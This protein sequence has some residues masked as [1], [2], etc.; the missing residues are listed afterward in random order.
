MAEPMIYRQNLKALAKQ[1]I[2]DYI[3]AMDLESNNKLPREEQL[4]EIIGVSR[5]TLRSA[6]NELASDG[7]VFRRQGKGTF[8]N[9]TRMEIKLSFN[10]AGH[11][12]DMIRDS[13]Y[14]PRIALLA[15]E[16]I[17]A[18]ADM[19]GALAIAEGEAVVKHKKLFYA[20]DTPCVYCEDFFAR[21]LVEEIESCKS[22]ESV[23]H[24]L[25]EKT[26]RKV[27]WDKVELGAV[28]SRD[29]P[30]LRIF[31]PQP[32]LRLHGI[33]FDEQDQPLLVTYEYVDAKRLIF[34]QIRHRKIIY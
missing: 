28:H 16:T 23:F 17:T 10:P 9:R 14:E 20:D 1:A 27:C 13:G 2:L 6:L 5:V 11:Y 7:T 12:S 3:A 33:N 19:A 22:T 21:S 24:Y 4:C 18:D 34:S 25:Y 15:V 31:P 30:E 32:L 26:G 8:V 29:K